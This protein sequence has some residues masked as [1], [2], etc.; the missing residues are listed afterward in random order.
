MTIK[1]ARVI[2]RRLMRLARI[3]APLAV[4]AFGCS[5]PPC[6]DLGDRFC[7]CQPAGAQRD[8]CKN[9]IKNA[10]SGAH[11]SKENDSL[12]TCLLSSCAGP[13]NVDFCDWVASDDAKVACGVSYP[14]TPN[15]SAPPAAEPGAACYDCAGG[16]TPSQSSGY[17]WCCPS[18]QS[19]TGCTPDPATQIVTCTCQ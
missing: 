14:T 3:L 17:A 7:S 4:L 12:C 19:A 9:Q 5:T 11:T 16:G 13:P 10:V 15:R 8:A 2:L 18:G 1:G 6:T